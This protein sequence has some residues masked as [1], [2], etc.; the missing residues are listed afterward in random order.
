VP[1]QMRQLFVAQWRD[2][3]SPKSSTP[4]LGPTFHS[5]ELRFRIAITNFAFR[6]LGQ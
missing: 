5:F 6:D 1:P 2:Q 4:L 3:M